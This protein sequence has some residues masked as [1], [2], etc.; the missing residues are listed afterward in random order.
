VGSI[1]GG[2]GMAGAVGA[3]VAGVV[4]AGVVGV[5]GV[6]GAGVERSGEITAVAPAGLSHEIP[7]T[8]HRSTKMS[9]VP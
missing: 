1:A 5:A 8:R 2:V 7:F 9:F 6:V 4:G 3:D